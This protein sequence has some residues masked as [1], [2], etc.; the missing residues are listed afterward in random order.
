MDLSPTLRSR[1]HDGEYGVR[2]L[3]KSGP[4]LGAVGLAMTLESLA[5]AIS[6]GAARGADAQIGLQFVEARAA[7]AGFTLDLAIRDSVTDTDDHC[8]AD[9]AG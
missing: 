7:A 6:A 9:L 2:G 3:G 4:T 8:G 1:G 5:G